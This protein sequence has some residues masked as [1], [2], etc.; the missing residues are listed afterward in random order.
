M[1]DKKLVALGMLAQRHILTTEWLTKE[2]DSKGLQEQDY[3]FREQAR[4]VFQFLEK[5]IQQVGLSEIERQRGKLKGVKM[6]PYLDSDALGNRPKRLRMV[7]VHTF[8]Q[9][10]EAHEAKD[11]NLSWRKVILASSWA[12]LAVG[13]NRLS[14][15]SE[16]GEKGGRKRAAKYAILREQIRCEAEKACKEW[17][18]AG[19]KLNGDAIAY[20]IERARANEKIPLGGRFIYDIVLEVKRKMQGSS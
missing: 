6:T 4:F 19:R 16:R 13:Q 7:A 2:E 15:M 12:A 9:A 5:F 18:K 11:T 8:I 3:C 17:Q 14:E 1:K 20:E 10:L